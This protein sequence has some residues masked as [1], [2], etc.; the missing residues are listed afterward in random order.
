MP[1]KIYMF[2]CVCGVKERERETE[3]KGDTG[4]ETVGGVKN[5]CR[6]RSSKYGL[7]I[8]LLQYG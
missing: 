4:G 1:I 5:H 7:L 3:K 8:F 6:A 2:V